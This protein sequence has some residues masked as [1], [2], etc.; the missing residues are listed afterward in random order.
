KP[1]RTSLAARNSASSSS[2][3]AI[4]CSPPRTSIAPSNDS[5]KPAFGLVCSIRPPTS[6]G[7]SSRCLMST[8]PPTASSLSPPRPSQSFSSRTIA[9]CS[10]SNP[11]SNPSLSSVPTPTLSTFYLVI[12]TVPHPI[13]PPSSRASASVSPTPKSITLSALRSP[14]AA[15]SR[16]PAPCFEPEAPVQNPGSPPNISPIPP[17]LVLPLSPASILLSTSSG[18]TS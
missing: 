1:A 16:F 5:S 15:P 11:P 17:F 10:L 12:T 9:T 8:R 7:L 2:Q 13:T 3:F 14:K 4:A 18:T 6:H